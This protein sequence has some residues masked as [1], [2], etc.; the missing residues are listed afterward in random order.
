M[1]KNER[2]KKNRDFRKIYNRGKSFVHPIVVV[3]VLPNFMDKNRVGFTVS[4]KIGGAVQRNRVKRLL[5]EVYNLVKP[6][7]QPGYDFIFLARP[8]IKNKNF[9]QIESAV[10]GLLKKGNF[11]VVGKRLK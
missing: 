6:N 5:R 3:Y 4:K 8:R 9:W 2:L 1:K 11:L 7:L 10:A